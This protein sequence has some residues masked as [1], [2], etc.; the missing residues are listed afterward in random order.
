L[1]K[2][3]TDLVDSKSVADAASLELAAATPELLR[4]EVARAQFALDTQEGHLQKIRN[5]VS[6]LQALLAKA[7]AE[8]RFEELSDAKAEQA[9]ATEALA[10][11]E[12]QARAARI[13]WDLTEEAYTD[14][15]RIFLGPVL[16]EAA[17]YLSN[18]RPGTEIR[19]TPDLRLDKVVRQGLEEDFGQ[20]SGGTREQL[21]V[22]VRIALARVFA[23]DRRPLP[24]I[25]DDTMGWTDDARFVSM[26]K[27][28][29]DAAKELQIILLTCHGTRFDRLK[30]DFRV[31]LD[32]L[33]R[34]AV[35]GMI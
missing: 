17:P 33:R 21:S 31:D 25:L 6:S 26:V 14:A 13:L 11:I 20:L 7:A 8:G 5:E 12:R 16:K 24:L 27:I 30:P 15:Q 4:D 3:Q 19:M 18:L 29:R 1:D 2:A 9:T 28:L 32:E 34:N 23:K 22:I 10:R 35:A